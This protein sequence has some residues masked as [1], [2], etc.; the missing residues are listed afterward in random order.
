MAFTSV[1]TGQRLA[2]ETKPFLPSGGRSGAV[3]RLGF[4]RSNLIAASAHKFFE[5]SFP[6]C[7]SDFGGVNQVIGQVDWG[8]RGRR[9]YGHQAI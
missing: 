9:R 4:G 5:R 6:Q 7:G 1:A 8:L 3:S 2:T